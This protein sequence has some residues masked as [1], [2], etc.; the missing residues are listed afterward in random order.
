[1]DLAL[2]QQ[3]RTHQLGLR[4]VVLQQAVALWPA[5]DVNQLDVTFPTY[6]L[7]AGSLAARGHSASTALATSYL[8]AAWAASG[9]AGTPALVTPPTLPLEQIVTA[10]RVTSVVAVKAAIGSGQTP[11]DAMA[12]GLVSSSGAIGRLAL[13]GGRDTIVQSVRA[14]PQARWE[15]ITS[16]T[17]C[18]FCAMLADRGE[19]YRSEETADFEAHD[20]CGCSA[21]A[22]YDDVTDSQSE[23]APQEG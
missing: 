18:D 16:A 22:S 5:L 21:A 7:A 2:A 23:P 20:H 14:Q 4:A 3:A 15:R 11:A 9:R 1:M 6:A 10:L 13:L 17:P 8:R 19:V 12:T